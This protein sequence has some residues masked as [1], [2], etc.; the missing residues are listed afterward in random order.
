[1]AW[2]RRTNGKRY[3]YRFR[4][5]G[6]RTIKIYVGAG[7]KGRAAAAEDQA[8]RQS[9]K[10]EKLAARGRA[11]AWATLLRQIDDGNV[12]L[13]ATLAQELLAAGWR[14]PAR[15]WRSPTRGHYTPQ[16]SS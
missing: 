16:S 15:T 11:A 8:Q 10:A 5:D 3:Y 2:E 9:R 7:E 12:I 1:M 6:N 14:K 13:Q 4:R